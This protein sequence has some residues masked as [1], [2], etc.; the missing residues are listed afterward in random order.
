MYLLCEFLWFYCPQA[1]GFN[2]LTMHDDAANLQALD[3]LAEQIK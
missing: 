2:Q 1:A 3:T